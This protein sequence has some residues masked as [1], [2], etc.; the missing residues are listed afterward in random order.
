MRI[1]IFKK[2]LPVLLE[3][4]KKIDQKAFDNSNL[5]GFYPTKHPNSDI[6]IFEI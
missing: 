3:E 5:I 6:L 2:I 1:E 4:N